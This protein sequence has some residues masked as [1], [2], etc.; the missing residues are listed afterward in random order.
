MLLWETDKYVSEKIMDDQ[1]FNEDEMNGLS[2]HAPDAPPAADDSEP[3]DTASGSADS[4]QSSA[5][6]WQERQLEAVQVRY[7]GICAE[8]AA[9]LQHSL[10]T[11][12]KVRAASV[13]VTTVGEF[14]LGMEMPTC[15]KSRTGMVD[16]TVL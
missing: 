15:L 12:V 5:S 8:L 6:G 11:D 1:V 2:G 4:E 16:R 14:I 9:E 10:G 13:Q 7:Q 3:V